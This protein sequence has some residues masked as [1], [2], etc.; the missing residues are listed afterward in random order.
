MLLQTP[1]FSGWSLPLRSPGIDSSE[2]IPE[3]IPPVY[4]AWRAGRA[5]RV[6]VPA[7]QAVNR[8]LGSLK[9]LQIQALVFSN[10]MKYFVLPPWIC[11]G[12]KQRVLNLLF[13]VKKVWMYIVQFL[14]PAIL[15]DITLTTRWCGQGGGGG[16]WGVSCKY[17]LY[18]KLA[19]KLYTL[20]G[21]RRTIVY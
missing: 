19:E 7:R 20:N 4:V 1:L 18:K 8:F 11:V 6:V 3:S 2:S 15:A 12:A 5:N 9:G 21:W 17:T 16:A 14:L 10:G 13:L